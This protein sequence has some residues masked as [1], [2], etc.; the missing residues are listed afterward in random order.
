MITT[1]INNQSLLLNYSTNNAASIWYNID[2][3]DN[4]TID[5]LTYFNT[6]EGGHILYLYASSIQGYTNSTNISFDI[7]LTKIT[8]DDE[9]FDNDI[10]NTNRKGDSIDLDEYPYEDLQNPDQEL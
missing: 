2:N 6:S 10:G 7:N 4:I 9:E 8:I 3:G 1:Y 5:S